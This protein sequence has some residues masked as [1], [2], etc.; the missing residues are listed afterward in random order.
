MLTSA[1]I[2]SIPCV[3]LL[4]SGIFIFYCRKIS[5]KNFFIFT[6][7]TF[8]FSVL[9]SYTH[10]SLFV[11]A[12][13]LAASVFLIK[14]TG[15]KQ[16]IIVFCITYISS[17]I[18]ALFITDILSHIKGYLIISSAET[19]LVDMILLF[20]LECITNACILFAVRYL[21]QKYLVHVFE[22]IDKRLFTFI[23]FSVLF[24]AL[25]IYAILT[26]FGGT[27]LT[28]F[29][30]FLIIAMFVIYFLL[31][32]VSAA[33]ILITTKK[34]YESRQKIDN[35]NTMRE[36]TDNLEATYNNLRSF[37][38][39]YVN[40][41][42]T[43]SIFIKE[44]RYPELE[45]YFFKEIMPMKD[46]LNQKN[47]SL[48]NLSRIGTLELKSLLY[49]KLLQAINKDIEVTVDIADEIGSLSIDS[50]DL[51]RV[52]GIYLDNAIEAAIETSHPAVNVHIGILDDSTTF[53]ISNSYVSRG[54]SISQM[55][56]K[57]VS[58]KGKERGLGLYNVSK[59]LNKY[60]N[61]FTETSITDDLFVQ[62]LQIL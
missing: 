50:V 44:K 45:E 27:D 17:C 19:N 56:Q 23:A 57:N 16:A 52:L 13:F 4:A 24:S 3:L 31:T 7:I 28:T 6:C 8:L 54:L 55:T 59:I 30:F 35:L 42:S 22:N 58:S 62:K 9:T 10:S 15:E 37:K 33:I 51:I 26:I 40:V 61:V 49:T 47:T 18:T 43:L 34:N 48:A 11:L 1:I 38:H 21:Y 5:P 12:F 36:Y 60:D 46:E 32:T 20:A 25:F 2:D 53:I 39:D 41:L 14:A 29:Q